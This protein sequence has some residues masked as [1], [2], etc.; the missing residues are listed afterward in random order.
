MG[1]NDVIL[2]KIDD[3]S[4]DEV[5]RGLIEDVDFID[6][7]CTLDMIGKK[8]GLRVAVFRGKEQVYPSVIKGKRLSL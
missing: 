5:L 1:L 4:V 3:L 6:V 2:A 7:A 8:L